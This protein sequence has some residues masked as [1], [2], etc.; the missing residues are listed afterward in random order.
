MSAGDGVKVRRMSL[1]LE[2]RPLDEP[3]G[4]NISHLISEF[5]LRQRTLIH[6]A[7]SR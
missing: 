2:D 4:I 5:D 6:A 3:V 1:A 7:P